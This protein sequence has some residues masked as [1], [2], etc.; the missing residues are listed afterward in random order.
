MR[1][2]LNGKPTEIASATTIS[3][4]IVEL[5]LGVRY[6]AVE[7]NSEPV[8]RREFESTV[9]EPGDVVEVVRPVQGG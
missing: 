6:V 3:L 9:L 2:T 1:I 4:L 8:H 7:R 5:G